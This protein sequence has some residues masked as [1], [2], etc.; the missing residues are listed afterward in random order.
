MEVMGLKDLSIKKK[1]LL[2][3]GVLFS[4]L[5]YFASVQIGEY[6]KSI[7]GHKETHL[8]L[9]EIEG[10]SILI[11]HLQAERG[12]SSGFV[13]SGK[14]KE[15]LQTRRTKTD[16]LL[17]QIKDKIPS[18]VLSRLNYIREAIDS[19]KASSEMVIRAY[20]ETID[21]IISLI[22]NKTKEIENHE[23]EDSLITHINLM[24]AKEY[25]GRVRATLYS[26]L[27][28]KGFTIEDYSLFSI[29][30]GL[31]QE[32]F[33]RFLQDADPDLKRFF[34]E[35]Y[36]G[37]EIG[38]ATKAIEKAL[39]AGP[40]R[41]LDIEPQEWWTA[42]S[43]AIDKLKSVEDYSIE[44]LVLRTEKAYKG[45]VFKNLI[46]VATILLVLIFIIAFSSYIG[47]HITNSMRRILLQLEKI[48][49]G[50]LSPEPLLNQKDEMGKIMEDIDLMRQKL[51]TTIFKIRATAEDLKVNQEA[52]QKTS[53]DVKTSGDYAAENSLSISTAV[54]EI[55]QTALTVSTSL[56]KLSKNTEEAL[57][58]LLEFRA[59]VKEVAEI[60]SSLNSYVEETSAS[61]EEGF[62]AIRSINR[63]IE[64]A[65]SKIESQAAALQE[66]IRSVANI[67]E[68]SKAGAD[69]AKDV[70]AMIRERGMKS[71][72]VTL[73]SIEE[74][75]HSQKNLSGV[76]NRVVSLSSDTKKVVQIIDDIAGET[77]LLSL[78]ASILAAQ[79]GEHGKAFS[80]VAEQ[81][82]SL[83]ERTSQNTKEISS[84]IG[85]F[86]T[87]AEELRIEHKKVEES[88]ERASGMVQETEKVFKEILNSSKTSADLQDSIKKAT[89]EQ[90]SALNEIGSTQEALSSHL[91]LII[92]AIKEQDTG[93]KRILEGTEM[94]RDISKNLKRA[95]E[96]MTGGIEIISKSEEEIHDEVNLIRNA[97]KDLAQAISSTSQRVEDL[98]RLSEENTRISN[99]LNEKALFVDNLIK[100]LE[101]DIKQFKTEGGPKDEMLGI[102][103]LS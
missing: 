3:S 58:A 80:V 63:S 66:V 102:Q 87:E 60:S 81:I 10:S 76:I 43:S 37:E 36:K 92:K 6:Y 13:I 46:V 65:G 1:L 41:R 15:E 51:Q 9:K 71:I 88:I 53:R 50:D 61:I 70:E 31:Y 100:K 38:F 78:N 79:A 103:K 23:L 26:V 30:Y 101:E 48:G 8:L 33:T 73:K 52:L 96:E 85:D 83:A 69:V 24:K 93:F 21:E 68:T 67:K 11:H 18:G 91:G 44:R 17:L 2:M 75:S 45:I 84:M 54:S 49:R 42:A 34:E 39:T 16:D 98:A 89:E 56:D 82:K 20:S 59:S 32:Y 12:I 7:R 86:I 94:V 28:R 14:G 97:M 95:T 5:L 55:N 90:A 72:E 40:Q 57:S 99:I 29:R 35:G 22:K 19:G 77:K 27:Y 47:R 64:E 4:V 74:I 62:S 25:L